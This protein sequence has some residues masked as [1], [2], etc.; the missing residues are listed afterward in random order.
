LNNVVLVS[1]L[2]VNTGEEGGSFIKDLCASQTEEEPPF[3]DIKNAFK[4]IPI[5]SLGVNS[6]FNFRFEI[7]VDDD[8]KDETNASHNASL[9]RFLILL[10][11]RELL[12]PSSESSSFPS[13]SIGEILFFEEIFEKFSRF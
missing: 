8:G 11:R 4:T 3:V 6:E 10:S 5:C 2:N 12:D 13:S 7:D 9:L 1:S